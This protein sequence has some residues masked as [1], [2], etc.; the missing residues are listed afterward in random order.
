[1]EPLFRA[2]TVACLAAD[3]AVAA[4]NAVVAAG[5]AVV[6]ATGGGQVLARERSFLR[7]PGL[8]LHPVLLP[9]SG[10]GSVLA[11]DLYRRSQSALFP[12]RVPKKLVWPRCPL[13]R[14]P[15]IPLESLQQPGQ[16][17][18]LMEIRQEETFTYNGVGIAAICPLSSAF[19]AIDYSPAQVSVSADW[20]IRLHLVKHRYL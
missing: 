15:G 4:E 11:K 13:R 6:A 9:F 7:H 14:T 2:A 3:T 19:P 18:K 10:I 8:L 5:N 17:R 1:V 12:L 16:K 20:H